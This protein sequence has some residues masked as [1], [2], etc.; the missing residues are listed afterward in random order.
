MGEVSLKSAVMGN[1]ARRESSAISVMVKT[2]EIFSAGL[3]AAKGVFDLLKRP[4]SVDAEEATTR[5]S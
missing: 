5:T 3:S 2:L 1:C 4:M